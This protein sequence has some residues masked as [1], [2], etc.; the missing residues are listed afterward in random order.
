MVG[1]IGA[2]MTVAQ[3]TDY[4]VARAL[5]DGCTKYLGASIRE[6]VGI[7]ED[8]TRA[9]IMAN[10]G[11]FR[12]SFLQWLKASCPEHDV[13]ATFARIESLDYAVLVA[14]GVKS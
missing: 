1:D 6:L 9:A 5:K 11:P 14:A 3:A 13:A 7:R 4:F 12:A 8:Y 10:D 2:R